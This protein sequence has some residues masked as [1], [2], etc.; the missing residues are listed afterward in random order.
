MLVKYFSLRIFR[1]LFIILS[2]LFSFCSTTNFHNS[3]FLS[4]SNKNPLKT[5]I[6]N[7]NITTTTEKK[8]NFRKL[9]FIGN[10]HE[11]TP[12]ILNYDQINTFSYTDAATS[13]T[14]QTEDPW[15][16]MIKFCRINKLI[17]TFKDGKYKCVEIYNCPQIFFAY[18]S[19]PN[20]VYCGC[21][22]NHCL[23]TEQ[24]KDAYKNPICKDNF[25]NYNGECITTLTD[26][27]FFQNKNINKEVYLL[28]NTYLD[29]F[30]EKYDLDYYFNFRLQYIISGFNRKE[31]PSKNNCTQK[32]PPN[33][34]DD[35]T[36]SINYIYDQNTYRCYTCNET[37]KE[38]SNP[39]NKYDNF[40]SECKDDFIFFLNP[41]ESQENNNIPENSCWEVCP[42]YYGQIDLDRHCHFCKNNGYINYKGLCLFSNQDNFV[43]G[44]WNEEDESF[45]Y[46][47]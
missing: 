10:D 38:C 9:S 35:T 11:I 21:I 30:M 3:S 15:I 26:Q 6:K 2:L 22:I 31:N 47:V 7:V 28:G 17:L 44:F 19:D 43:D 34:N 29:C 39:P 8:H 33:N 23:D 27:E 24:T 14:I 25:L 40:C 16:D 4:T 37:C 1:I 42:I 18:N 41:I 32:C 20:L 5:N 45:Y 46:R 13:S 12:S 36:T